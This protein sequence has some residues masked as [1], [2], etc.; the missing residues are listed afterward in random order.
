MK[1]ITAT[2]LPHHVE[3]NASQL[4]AATTNKGR[5]LHL[6]NEGNCFFSQS[7]AIT[8]VELEGFAF[9]AAHSLWLLILG[10]FYC[11]WRKLTVSVI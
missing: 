4:L 5:D 1:G 6:T 2:K 10:F 11:L 7:I 3:E 9:K 8:S